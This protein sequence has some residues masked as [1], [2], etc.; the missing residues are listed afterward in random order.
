MW[1]RFTA[2]FAILALLV[3]RRD[4]R[5]LVVLRRPPPLALAAAV[6]LLANYLCFLW[7]LDHTTP[8]NAQVLIQLA[9][10]LLAGCGVLV[11]GETMNRAQLLAV[12]VAVVGFGLFYRDQ[13]SQLVGDSE[14]YVTGNAILLVAA[15]SWALYAV[16]QKVL[17][18]RGHA[19]QDLN[20]VLY[21][22][23]AVALLP[24]ADFSV[25]AGLSAGWWALLVFLALNTLVAYGA[26]G[27]ALK[28]LPAHEVSLVITCNPLMT[29][30][31]MATLGALDVA[32]IAPD[33]VGPLGWVAAGLVIGG[34][35]RALSKR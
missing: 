14:R 31:A 28:R 1:F 11:F 32:W 2:A 23:P 25:L 7:A 16:L 10:L 9:P 34:V 24:F 21:A 29:L 22:L 27:E 19:P 6:L 17:T 8:S 13:L 12:G 4:R 35:A 33:R 15:V 26:L 30:A 5:R 20:L 18:R 3:G